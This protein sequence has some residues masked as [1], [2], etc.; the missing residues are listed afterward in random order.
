MLVARWAAECMCP[1]LLRKTCHLWVAVTGKET[2]VHCWRRC[3]D[4]STRMWTPSQLW[5]L[6]QSLVLLNLKAEL[7]YMETVR[8]TG[9]W[10]TTWLIMKLSATWHLKSVD[11]FSK[12]QSL[13]ANNKS[14][15]LSD[16]S[17][18]KEVQRWDLERSFPLSWPQGTNS[19]QLLS[20]ALMEKRMLALA[21]SMTTHQSTT[22]STKDLASKRLNKVLQSTLSRWLVP[23]ATCRH[24]LKCA[25]FPVAQSLMSKVKISLKV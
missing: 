13:K 4:V 15:R 2:Q 6:P 14:K 12:S 9:K 20:F 8:K 18:Q 5:N 10:W 19:V 24:Y 23:S 1:K 21:T 11:N 25:S 16:R 22:N 3:S 17:R 7:K